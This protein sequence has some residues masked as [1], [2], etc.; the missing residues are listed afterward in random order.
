M[1]IYSNGSKIKNIII[2][3]LKEF[4]K[5]LL[6][7]FYKYLTPKGVEIMSKRLIYMEMLQ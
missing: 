3:L 6:F 4:L 5:V 7:R 2:E 1:L